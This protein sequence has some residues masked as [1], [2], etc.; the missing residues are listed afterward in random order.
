M[1]TIGL[2]QQ[3]LNQAFF[4]FNKYSQRDLQLVESTD[5]AQDVEC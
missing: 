3:S 4:F 5:E 1:I 2:E